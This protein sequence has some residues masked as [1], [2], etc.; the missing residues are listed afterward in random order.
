MPGGP[1]SNT[2]FGG[3]VLI[4]LNASANFIGHSTASISSCLGASSPPTSCHFTFGASTNT[5]RIADGSMF[6]WTLLKS[7]AV[8]WSLSSTSCEI[9]CSRSISGRIFRSACI[10][11][12]LDR[13]ARSAP[14]KPC[15]V[16]ARS[17]RRTSPVMGM[18]LVCTCNIWRRPAASGTPISISL[19]NRPGL[20]SAGSIPS[21]RLVAAI[22]TTSP[23]ASRPSI[24]ASSWRRSRL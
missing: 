7:S 14:T 17:S 11:A 22:T 20:R 10:A 8:T 3:F 19:S 12:S 18:P 5:S 1:K 15:V 24:N 6:F 13:A 21:G 16:R 23:R 2:P 9:S 4:V